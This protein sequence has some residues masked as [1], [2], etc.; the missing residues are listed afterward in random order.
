MNLWWS[1]RDVRRGTRRTFYAAAAAWLWFWLPPGDD[2]S[3][4]WLAALAGPVA[5][6]VVYRLIVRPLLPDASNEFDSLA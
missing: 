5:L 2:G 4:Q 6:F 1:A 3:L